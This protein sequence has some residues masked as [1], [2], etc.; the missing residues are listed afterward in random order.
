M[1]SAEYEAHWKAIGE[2]AVW[3]EAN[4][5]NRNEA[6]T[7]L[8]LIDRIFFDCLGWNRNDAV[9]EEAHNGQ[10]ADYT[11]SAPRRLL[12]VE[13]KKEGTY[14]ELPVGLTGI[15]TT[16]PSLLRT[17]TALKSA[18]EQVAGYCQSRGVPYAAVTNGHQ[19]VVFVATRSD[20]VPPFE[21]RA[22]VFQS[23]A[24]MRDRFLDFW[25]ILSKP[26]IEKQSLRARLFAK[27]SVSLPAKLSATIKPYPGT[28]GRNPFQSSMK[29]VSEFILEDA[30]KAKNLEHTFLKACYCHSGALSSYSLAS[31]QMLRSRY[32]ALFDSERPGPS[33][34]PVA[35][36]GE[37]NP[38]FLAQTFSRRPI[39]LIG[40]VG[41]GKTSFLRNLM[42]NEPEYLSEKALALYIDLGTTGALT[43]DLRGY[44]L[45]Q[46]DHQMLFDHGI[47]IRSDDIV[48]DTFSEELRNMSTLLRHLEA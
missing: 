37:T 29:A 30:A 9:A 14:F 2:V 16:I 43:T 19:I 8:Q 7:R 31:K 28:K 23:I 15:E 3:Y 26:A 27:P 24:Q 45:S 21:G 11:F 44:I 10:Y 38:E 12:I 46:I 35:E 34:R 39:L 36:R 6:T 13:A 42:T 1:I 32:A 48:R 40:D 4:A 47:D 20:G 22:L 18:L 33:V 25:N 5:A 17:T 41:V